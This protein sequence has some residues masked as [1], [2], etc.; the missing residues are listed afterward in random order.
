MASLL[1]HIP[2]VISPKMNALCG[3]QSSAEAGPKAHCPNHLW[4]TMKIEVGA[5]IMLSRL[6]KSSGFSS[7]KATRLMAPIMF[8]V[9]LF[10]LK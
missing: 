6:L 2:I 10:S 9:A 8:H 4:G 3:F 5:M 7:L 1:T